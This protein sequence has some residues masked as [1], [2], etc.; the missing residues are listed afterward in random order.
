MTFNQ[1]SLIAFFILLNFSGL[2]A[3][4]GFDLSLVAG[5]NASQIAGDR[6]AGFDKLGLNTGLKIGYRIK[7]KMDLSLEMLFSQKGS[8]AKR[9]VSGNRMNT[10]LS[11]LEFPVYIT[12]NDWYLEKEDYFKVGIH[13]GLSYSYLLSR[14]INNVKVI[15]DDTVRD[16][17]IMALAGVHYAFTKNWVLTVRYANS[18]IRIYKDP[19]DP[20]GDGWI[21]YHWTVRADYSF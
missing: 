9:N 7:S 19:N 3:Q 4:R 5:F 12:Y 6:L 13:G 10:T 14:R 2:Q 21:N 20:S 11:Y 17:D 16:F 15:N 1:L 18:F 8:I